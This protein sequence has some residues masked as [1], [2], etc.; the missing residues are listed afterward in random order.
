MSATAAVR[1]W[2][3]SEVAHTP[4]ASLASAPAVA[5]PRVWLYTRLLDFSHLPS[6]WARLLAFLYYRVCR[7][8]PALRDDDGS[9]KFYDIRAGYGSRA[10]AACRCADR[11]DVVVGISFGRDYGPHVAEEDTFCRP[12]HPRYEEQD[13]RDSLIYTRDLNVGLADALSEL[14]EVARLAKDA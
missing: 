2:E 4:R 13:A 5:V 9:L 12:R 1:G 8:P 11:D 7:Q 14:E 6:A 10:E 3:R